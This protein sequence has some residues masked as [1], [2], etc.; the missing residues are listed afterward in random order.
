MHDNAFGFSLPKNNVETLRAQINEK[1][2]DVVIEDV[3]HVDYEIAAGR[4]KEKHIKQVGQWKNMW[5]NTL[6]E[7]TFAIT[8]IYVSSEDIKLLGEKKNIIKF[9]IMRGDNRITFIKRF[10]SEALYNEIIH[11]TAHGISSG[12]KRLKL[13]VIG[14]F[15]INKYNDN[16]YPQVEIVDILSEVQTRKVMF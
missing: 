13:T 5:A 9:E 8:D 6:P 1:L 16:E 4:L 3:Y 2:K 12:N 10:A 11:R 14:K 15:S 7:P